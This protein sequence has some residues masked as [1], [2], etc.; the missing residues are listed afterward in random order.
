MISV[1][2]LPFETVKT[3]EEQGKYKVSYI[4]TNAPQIGIFTEIHRL[5]LQFHIY[6]KE[7]GVL[8]FNHTVDLTL[9]RF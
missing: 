9:L 5:F 1:G 6:Q 4:H 7:W 2:S 8:S 3:D